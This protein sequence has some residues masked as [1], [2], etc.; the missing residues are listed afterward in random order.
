MKTVPHEMTAVKPGQDTT[1]FSRRTFLA[2]S[3]GA[4][5][6][7]AFGPLGLA[8]SARA[9]IEGRRFSPTVWF[10]MDEQGATLINIA[11]AEM[12]QHVGTSLARILADELGVSWED[13]SIKH[14]DSDPRWGYMVTGGSWSVFT[15]FKML[16]QAGAA[17]RTVLIEAGAGML[18]AAPADC[19]AED[20]WVIA[21]E[22]KVSY[23]EIVSKGD[24]DRSFTAEELEAMPVKPASERRIIGRPGGALD[25]PAKTD[26][27][28]AY[29]IDAER[30][31]MVYARPLVPPTRY[32]SKV[33][34]VDDSAAKDIPGY[35]G[36][37]VL[38]D[39]SNTLQ[40]WVSALA[41]NYW[42][43]V[44]AGDAIKVDWTAGPTA[45]V[46]EDDIL[47]EGAKLA[48][49]K[50]TGTLV[51]NDGDVD[52]AAAAAARSVSAIYRTSSVLHF[53][54]EPN[55]AVAEF[56][57]GKWQLYSGNQWQSLIL[58]LLAKALE[59][60]EDQ[61]VI[62]QYYLG[63]GYGRRLFGDY[64]LPAALTAKAVGKPVKLVFTRPDDA[65]FDCARSPSVQHFSASIDGDGKVSGIEHAA[66]A[67]WPT[68]TMAPGFMFDGLD[69]SGKADP[70]SINGAEHW[71]TLPGHRVRALMNP[72]AQET[73][74][75]GWLRSVGPG[76]IGWGVES[77]M[78]ELAH[79]TGQDPI[80]FRLS[81]LDAS[82][83]N[84]G[85]KPQTAGG[86]TRLAAVLRRT[87]ERSGWG[88]ELPADEGLGVAACAGQERN[89]PTWIACVAHVKVDRASGR[90]KVKRLYQTID[91]GTRV[92]P[93]GAMA[94][95][96]GASLWGLSL[97]LHEGTR[98]EQGQVADTNLDS[99]TPL[100]MGDVP[101]LDIEFIDSD[102]FPVGM[103]EPPVIVIGPAI[104][105]AIYSAV[106][107]RVRDLP[108]RPEAVLEQLQ[109]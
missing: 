33:N 93:D 56:A 45:G 15:T 71:Y 83:K 52:A 53:Q 78:D 74:L 35:I 3:M 1:S 79:V 102:A 38:E 82:G 30:P 69:D 84:A 88:S 73:F 8:G 41:D 27:T 92:H 23:A 59:V 4:S 91:C 14:V 7:M 99:Y 77:F 97:A 94:Q 105:N 40:G 42:S 51:V 109:S 9:A 90:V 19:R 21:G 26:G 85:D 58:P 48:K 32:G 108:I 28:A 75:P 39:P 96:Q 16:S 47:A 20:G 12:G 64:M 54:L 5:L 60:P 37:Q 65:R 104:A 44:K 68:Q 101:E 61:V 100:R 50:G 22:K 6:V 10:E 66:V 80:A 29:G 25:I 62:H 67:G 98:F 31:G 2:G 17:G 13:V 103:G 36:Y 43:A 89:M 24:I 87:R 76:W 55:N 49:Q 72:V 106:G 63:G 107:V 70:F 86:A 46:S 81:M 57:D 11:K 34:G 95:A 18:G